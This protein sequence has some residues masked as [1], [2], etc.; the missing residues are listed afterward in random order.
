MLSL[1]VGK[2]NPPKF[3]DIKYS[4]APCRIFKN[5]PFPTGVRWTPSD[6]EMYSFG[7]YLNLGTWYNDHQV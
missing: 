1:W 5:M 4:I 3:D 7:I 2:V 6:L